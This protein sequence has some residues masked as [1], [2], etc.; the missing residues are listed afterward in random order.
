MTQAD[1]PTLAFKNLID[2][3]VNPFTDNEVNNTE[4]YKDYQS[5]LF[6]KYLSI[7]ENNG[8]TFLP[9][10]WYAVKNNVYDLNNWEY[11]GHH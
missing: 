10:D 1:V 5:V 2:N 4:K 9:G 6:S 7:D 3:P 8:N 11:I